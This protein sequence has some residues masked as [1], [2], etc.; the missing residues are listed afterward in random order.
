MLFFCVCGCLG[1]PICLK[2]TVCSRSNLYAEDVNISNFF[3]MQHGTVSTHHSVAERWISFNAVCRFYK[4]VPA[5]PAD[6]SML[7]ISD[8]QVSVA[9]DNICRDESPLLFTPVV[10]FY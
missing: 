6:F 1:E 3:L 4:T 2:E 10:L 9:Y 7:L 8:T 5:R